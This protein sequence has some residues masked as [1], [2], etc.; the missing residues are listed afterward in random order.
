[1]PAGLNGALVS[2]PNAVK[3]CHEA[4]KRAVACLRVSTARQSRS[5]LGLEAQRQAVEAFAAAHGF[6]I[7]AELVEVET[8][9]GSDALS[10][11]RSLP[12]PWSPPGSSA[13]ARRCSSPSEHARLRRRS[14]RTDP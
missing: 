11:G 2:N 5:G 6:T 8:G 9:K 13:R 10:A 14:P 12:P 7:A 4:A 3:S 1:V